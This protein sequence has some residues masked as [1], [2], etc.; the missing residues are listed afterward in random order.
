M[1]GT[2]ISDVRCSVPQWDDWRHLGMG[3]GSGRSGLAAGD[4]EPNGAFDGSM[5]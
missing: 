2:M 1:S 3:M 4:E 5:E